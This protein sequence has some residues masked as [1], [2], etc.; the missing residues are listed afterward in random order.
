[1]TTLGWII[2]VISWG[3]IIALSVF[4]FYKILKVKKDNI[5]APLDIDTGD[6]EEESDKEHNP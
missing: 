2:L 6:L 4:C 1:M 5:H 3:A